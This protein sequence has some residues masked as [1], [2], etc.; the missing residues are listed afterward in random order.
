ML[1]HLRLK[2]DCCSALTML[3]GVIGFC[4]IL[5]VQISIDWFSNDSSQ[6]MSVTNRLLEGR[7]L[8]T[9]VLYFDHQHAR[10]M[11]ALQTFW[12]PGLPVIA[13]FVASLFGLSA[14][15]ALAAA[16]VAAHGITALLLYRIACKLMPRPA[17]WHALALGIG[18]LIY[19][20]AWQLA[21]AGLSESYFLL[22]LVISVSCLIKGLSNERVNYGWLATA[23][24]AVGFSCLFRY[25][26]VTFIASLGA[27]GIVAFY[28]KVTLSTLTRIVAC[29]TG[30]GALIFLA[31]MVRNIFFSDVITGGATA[32]TG[33]PF[34][35]V[36]QG[37]YWSLQA[38]IGLTSTDLW[39]RLLVVA[40]VASGL[41]WV[42]LAL[43]QNMTSSLDTMRVCIVTHCIGGGLITVVL[44]AALSLKTTVYI[45]EPRY[46]LPCLLLG[47]VALLA[48][49]PKQPR[50][51]VVATILRNTTLISAAV[52]LLAHAWPV[53]PKNCA[54]CAIRSA[55]EAEIGG[56]TLAAFLSE[57]ATE[58]SPLMSNQAQLLHALIDRPTIGIPSARLTSVDWTAEKIVALAR[59]FG[60]SIV[61]VCRRLPEGGDPRDPIL[62][63]VRNPHPSLKKFYSDDNIILYRLDSN[64][65]G[66]TSP[67]ER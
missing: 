14:A 38:A 29:V 16:N 26:A 30:P 25:Q 23:S 1:D 37:F 66:N 67:P 60:V 48:M 5:L 2:P 55:L 52:L 56:Q 9:S 21:L 20:S 40:M 42:A 41:G 28:G 24:L 46:L 6:Y 17:R 10:G 45:F 4:S 62:A 61:A 59:R 18:Y 63:A 39:N 65:S 19:Y 8:R 43:R 22:G 33:T 35:I 53:P 13:A 57:S 15:T 34:G 47:I 32:A 36:V 11:P 64:S 44:I 50:T 12:P 54:M 51:G 3:L 7:G 31:L 58:A 27:A 49:W